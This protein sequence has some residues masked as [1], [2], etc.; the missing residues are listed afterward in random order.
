MV[1]ERKKYD[2]VDIAKFIASLFVFFMHMNAFGDVS[3]GFQFYGIQMLARWGVP[4]FFCISSFFL[5]RDSGGKN[6]TKEKLL[7]YSKRIL[8][9]YLVWFVLNSPYIAYKLYDSGISNKNTWFVFI[10][11]AILSSTFMGSWYLISSVFSAWFVYFLSKKFSTR[12][13][14]IITFIIYLLC[15]VTSTYS[16]FIDDN[17]MSFISKYIGV[18]CN[19]VITG[20]FF[21]S[22][23]KY[24]SENYGKLMELP[25]FVCFLGLFFSY[26]LFY[27][28]IIL[29]KN[30][31]N[32]YVTDASLFLVPIAF[33]IVI[34]LL[35]IDVKVK[36]SAYYR[37]A[38]TI[39]YCS[40]G[41]VIIAARFI[42]TYLIGNNHSC[43]VWAIACVEMIAVIA[44]ILYLEKKTQ[45]KLIKNLM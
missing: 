24:I 19:I 13:V 45:S 36:G 8:M 32:F 37:K 11:N 1:E 10:R 3:E 16:N 38:S 33:F 26:A 7:K 18:T 30:T 43:V 21:F 2:A 23:G 44:T 31:G 39:I 4:F 29:L 41:M 27:F 20:C 9:L 40:Q 25:K 15:V 35:K 42:S 28:E 5:F 34:L 14:L 17:L 6:I 12:N 22:L